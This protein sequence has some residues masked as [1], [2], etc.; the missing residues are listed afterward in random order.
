MNKIINGKVSK[1]CYREIKD[2][3][4]FISMS[5]KRRKRKQIIK[6]L[7]VFALLVTVGS[8]FALI[9]KDSLLPKANVVES[10]SVANN[11]YLMKVV[12]SAITLKDSGMK[13]EDICKSI[14]SRYPGIYVNL[15]EEGNIEIGYYVNGKVEIISSFYIN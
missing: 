15:T 9:N 8:Y 6:N 4:S 1:K 2:A 14:S 7:F 11:E 13:G 10:V 12:D 3:R 5:R